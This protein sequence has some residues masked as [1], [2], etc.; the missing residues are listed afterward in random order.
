VKAGWLLS[1]VGALLLS[2][3]K[4][5]VIL[6]TNIASPASYKCT[7]GTLHLE[8]KQMLV[9]QPGELSPSFHV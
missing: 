4:L 1:A 8:Q 5:A 7:F 2:Y 6:E 3:P 9:S